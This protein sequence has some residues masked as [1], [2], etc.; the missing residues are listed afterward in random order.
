[1][2]DNLHIK[3]YPLSGGYYVWSMSGRWSMRLHN[4]IDRYE[5]GSLTRNGLFAVLTKVFD[6]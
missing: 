1:M 2:T 4:A 6:L 3:K 5:D